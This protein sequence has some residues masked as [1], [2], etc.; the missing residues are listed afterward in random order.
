M[1][2]QRVFRPEHA[3]FYSIYRSMGCADQF[4]NENRLICALQ[5]ANFGFVSENEHMGCLKFRIVERA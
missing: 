5:K 3:S 1:R 2:S 4:V